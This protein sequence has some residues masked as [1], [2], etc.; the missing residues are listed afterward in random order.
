[1][2]KFQVF[3]EVGCNWKRDEVKTVNNFEKSIFQSEILIIAGLNRHFHDF[4][5]SKSKEFQ[6]VIGD[7][8]GKLGLGILE[9]PTANFQIPGNGTTRF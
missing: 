7:I 9:T 4:D 6:S 5:F 8:V 1:M 2:A 3:G